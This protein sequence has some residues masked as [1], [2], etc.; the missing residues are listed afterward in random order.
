MPYPPT[1]PADSPPCLRIFQRFKFRKFGKFRLLELFSNRG[2]ITHDLSG[3]RKETNSVVGREVDLYGRRSLFDPHGSTSC[4]K[5]LLTKSIVISN[6]LLLVSSKKHT[7]TRYRTHKSTTNA[8]VLNNFAT[9]TQGFI[10]DT[11]EFCTFYSLNFVLKAGILNSL[12]SPSI[13]WTILLVCTRSCKMDEIHLLY[14]Q[15][16]TFTIAWKHRVFG[17]L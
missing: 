5:A 9:A 14:R 3:Q 11:K 17:S 4:M 16:F 15:G 13:L 6:L 12:T 1:G 10:R 8:R 7:T 2:I